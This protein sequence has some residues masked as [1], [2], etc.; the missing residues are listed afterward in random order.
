MRAKIIHI[1][2][3]N[4]MNTNQLANTLQ[5]D[6]STIEH[7][8]KILEEHKL[9]AKVGERYSVTYFLSTELEENYSLF[10]EIWERI[11]KK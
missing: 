11:G 10:L 6:Y 5:L 9:V 1:L 3:E 8:V 4:P 7:H 2:K